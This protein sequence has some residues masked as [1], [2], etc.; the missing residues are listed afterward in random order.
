[1]LPELVKEKNIHNRPFCIRLER[2]LFNFN[3]KPTGCYVV[4]TTVTQQICSFVLLPKWEESF[5]FRYFALLSLKVITTFNSLF[6]QKGKEVECM[7]SS[8]PKMK[9]IKRRK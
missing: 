2:I 5:G 3:V 9:K 8:T 7:L 6:G 4:A 1:M